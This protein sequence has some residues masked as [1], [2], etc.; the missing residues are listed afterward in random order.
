LPAH[1]IPSVPGGRFS[2]GCVAGV[3]PVRR[4]RVFS[5][6]AVSNRHRR[7]VLPGTKC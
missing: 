6:L 2:L 4:R 7:R 1:D 3:A 5:R